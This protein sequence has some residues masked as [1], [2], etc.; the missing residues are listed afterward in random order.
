MRRLTI[1]NRHS[2]L[3]V[4]ISA[5]AENQSLKKRGVIPGKHSP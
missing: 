2:N 1:L 5:L 3:M 4:A